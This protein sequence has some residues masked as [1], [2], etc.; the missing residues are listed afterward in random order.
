MIPVPLS[1]LED[2]AAPD[3]DKDATG[4]QPQ[5][6]PQQ[7][8]SLSGF[9]RKFKGEE[10]GK[11]DEF[12]MVEMTRGEYLKYWAKDEEERYIGTEPE[13]EGAKRLRERESGSQ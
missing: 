11:K 7:R 1:A 8:R 13:G 3:G 4:G 12:K 9:L 10:K 5:Q 6:P 2:P